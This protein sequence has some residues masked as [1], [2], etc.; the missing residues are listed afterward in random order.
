MLTER[1]RVVGHKL[2]AEWL[3][4]VGEQDN[5]VLAEHFA[6]GGEPGR[7]VRY[8]L[9]AAIQALRGGD[10]RAALGR[11]KRA[12]LCGADSETEKALL[13]IQS[14]ALRLAGAGAVLD[15]AEALFQADCEKEAKTALGR[16]LSD[17]LDQAREITEP[18]ARRVFWENVPMRSRAFE[19]AKLWGVERV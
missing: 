14:E 7:A 8:Y 11:V 12:F 4:S 16:L 5:L 1:D 10:G 2:A 9:G 17:L 19:L 15:H 18:E 13:A 6:R 3:E